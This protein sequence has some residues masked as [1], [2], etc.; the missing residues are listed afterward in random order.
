MP[1]KDQQ[2]R[3]RGKSLI[4]NFPVFLCVFVVSSLL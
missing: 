1:L 3:E 2:R 4:V